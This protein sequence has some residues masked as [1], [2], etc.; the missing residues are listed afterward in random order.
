MFC[1]KS[2]GDHGHAGNDCNRDRVRETGSEKLIKLT[3]AADNTVSAGLVAVT[4][5]SGSRGA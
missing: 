1:L 3:K 5:H 4:S 2:S